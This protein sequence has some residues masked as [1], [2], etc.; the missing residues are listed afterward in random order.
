VDF[1]LLALIDFGS[2]ENKVV[3]S[4]PEFEI[5]APQLLQKRAILEIAVPH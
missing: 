5:A 2:S 3:L 1:I 4:W